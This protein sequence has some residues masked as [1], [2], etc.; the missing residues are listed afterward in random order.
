MA[1]SSPGVNS[2][3]LTSVQLLDGLALA[4]PKCRDLSLML[5]RSQ[6]A[7]SSGDPAK[8]QSQRLWESVVSA[9]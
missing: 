1:A 5:H 9:D 4:F 3:P 7:G 2:G 8:V 6:I